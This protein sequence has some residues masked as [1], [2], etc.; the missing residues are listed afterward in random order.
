MIDW[1][2]IRTIDDV[3]HLDEHLLFDEAEVAQPMDMLKLNPNLTEEEFK[4]AFF[5]KNYTRGLMLVTGEPGSGKTSL[6]HL[7]SYKMKYYFNKVAVLDTR[8]RKAYGAY[9]P[10]SEDMLAEQVMRMSELETGIPR[11]YKVKG[12][13]EIDFGDDFDGWINY[14]ELSVQEKYA[15]LQNK[16]IVPKSAT[17]RDYNK[18]RDEFT[19]TVD[20]K[21]YVTADGKWIT[22]RGEI[23]LR[24]SVVGMDEFGNKYMGR[25]SSPTLKIKVEL[26]KLFNF[27]R[28]MH[29]L[30]IG[31]GVS[32]DDFDRKCL[33]KATWEA[34]CVRVTNA[35]EHEI[36]PDAIIL[37]AYITPIKYNP[38]S[39]ELTK[40]GRTEKYRI[41]ASEPK[42][43][44]G[45][46]SWKE[47]FNT[48]NSQGFDVASKQ[49]RE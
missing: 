43:I 27:W 13:T 38:V 25:L 23:F 39:D 21:P 12:L 19:A 18:R 37:G 47:I 49:R 34:R 4:D 30:M 11:P 14:K 6:L 41:N 40:V 35:D 5:W 17:L 16:D 28:H 32:L 7:I 33:S 44:L 3:F 8:P 31:A 1:S 26:L 42:H 29:C 45:G 46:R 22:S 15:V 20:L 2:R 36:D 48:D 24:N 9:I 10:F